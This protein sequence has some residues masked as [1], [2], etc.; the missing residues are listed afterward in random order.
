MAKKVYAVRKGNIPGVFFSWDECKKSIDG[1]SGVEYKGFASEKEAQA[2]LHNDE[3]GYAE[4]TSSEN[5][6]A[7]VAY[8]DGSYEESL[9]T[10]AYGC[11]LITPKGEI[12]KESGC[13]NKPDG[14]ATR[15]VAGELLGTIHA[16]RWAIDNGYVSIVIK[17]DYEGISKWVTGEWKARNTVTQSYIEEMGKMKGAID[18]SFSK[19]VAHSNNAYNDEAD[20]LAKE[21]LRTGKKARISRGDF[22]LSAEGIESNDIEAV[23]ELIKEDY[24]EITVSKTDIPYAKRIEM[25]FGKQKVVV[26]Y[27]ESKRLVISGKPETLFSSVIS[28]VSELVDMDKI[29]EIFNSAFNVDIKKEQ[30]RT[31]F[32]M[33]LPYSYNKLPDKLA[34]TLHQAIYNLSLHG[35]FFDG[36]FLAHPAFRGLEAHLKKML[37]EQQIIPSVQHIKI[38]GFDMFDKSGGKYYLKSNKI[39]NANQDIAQNINSCYTFYNTNRNVFFHWD[40]PAGPLD[41]TVLLSEAVAHQKI[42]VVLSLIDE[43]YKLIG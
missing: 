17:H 6:N 36:T 13:G 40:D 21:A 4:V 25:N 1:Y 5:Q 37:V 41:T 26:C 19:V 2:Y 7:L 15:N 32:N 31:E 30:I 20:R 33:L 29:P 43:Y 22:W 35:D 28:L 11:V 27:Y 18:I 42:K 8:V 34:R 38:N 39:G 12:I 10:Y 24:P 14:I 9:K 16:T 23:I 3:L